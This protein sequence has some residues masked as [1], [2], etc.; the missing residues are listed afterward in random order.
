MFSILSSCIAPSENRVSDNCRRTSLMEPI[1]GSIEEY[2][3]STDEPLV[4][5]YFDKLSNPTSSM[6]VQDI[7]IIF[8]ELKERALPNHKDKFCNSCPLGG[9]PSQ[10]DDSNTELLHLIGSN[11]HDA[12]VISIKDGKCSYSIGGKTFHLENKENQP[13]DYFL[14][15]NEISYSRLGRKREDL[16]TCTVTGN[17]VNI[18]VNGDHFFASLYNSLESTQK[19]DSIW[20]TGWDINPDV[21][22]LPNP[23]DKEKSEQSKIQTVLLRAIRRDVNVLILLNQNIYNPVI[24]MKFAHPLNKA[25]G[26]TVCAPDNRH[27]S[28]FGNLH[29]KAWVINRNDE[30]I[31]YVGSMDIASGR[32]D[33]KKHDKD[34]SWRMEPSFTQNY[35]GWTGGMLEV[36]GPAVIDIARHLYNQFRDP[37]HPAHGYKLGNVPEWT[38]PPI[39]IY[40]SASQIQTLLT[41]GQKGAVNHSYYSNWA[42]KGEMSILAGTLKAIHAAKDFIFVSDQFLWC[43]EIINAI[44]AKLDNVKAVVLLT[45]GYKSMDHELLS[46]DITLISKAKA[47]YQHQALD[48]LKIKDPENK[49]IHLY[50]TIKEGMPDNDVKNIIYN[51]WKVLIIDDEFAIIGTAGIE[52][53][54]MTNDLDMSLGIYDK[55]KIPGIRKKLWAE[56]LDCQ[57]NDLRLD[58][59][60]KAIDTLWQVSAKNNGRV[61]EYW[62]PEVKYHMLYKLIY[63]VFEPDGV[64]HKK[65]RDTPITLKEL[66]HYISAYTDKQRELL[67]TL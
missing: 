22:L 10:F 7:K 30:T 35:A 25:A 45:D 42:P 40:Q 55:K 18:L 20:M 2:F 4:K 46:H 54:G 41:A 28:I 53:A 37:V 17:D 36:K 38:I 29:Q 64:F 52:T 15:E 61:R 49:K 23:D 57:E 31:A 58:D 50:Q 12:L 63:D 67:Q 59:P 27:N 60:I 44:A 14:T 48:I 47:Y 62:P 66:R 32:Y 65:Y 1:F 34:A 9:L 33:T 26:R 43:P 16:S 8:S 3:S 39:K 24:A 21:M 13:D 19:G 6:T 51:H 56:Y 5:E 11:G